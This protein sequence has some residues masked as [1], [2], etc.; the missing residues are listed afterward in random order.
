MLEN[1]LKLAM[2][3]SNAYL[4]G[5]RIEQQAAGASALDQVPV[6]ENC[7]LGT[8]QPLALLYTRAVSCHANA[9]LLADYVT[10]MRKFD[11]VN[12]AKESEDTA[13]QW[14]GFAA[15]RCADHETRTKTASFTGNRKRD[16]RRCL[17]QYPAATDGH[18]FAH[19]P[20]GGQKETADVPKNDQGHGDCIR[21]CLP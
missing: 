13:D 6:D 18:R 3:W 19:G 21:V 4:D 14:H 11:A 8:D 15:D 16:P 10:M 17:G 12:D 9:L 5:W 2:V 1:R 20:Q 7:R